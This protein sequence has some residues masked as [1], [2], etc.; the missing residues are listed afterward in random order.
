M[1]Q[2][3]VTLRCLP[4]SI[5]DRQLTYVGYGY[6]IQN[7]ELA[8]N[9]DKCAVCRYGRNI[10]V[11]SDY[12]SSDIKLQEVHTVKDLGVT[13]D[14]QLKFSDH[15]YD[16]IKKAYSVLGLIK[17]NSNFLCRDSFVMLYKSMVRSH[18]EYANAVWNPHKEGLIKDL[19]WIQMR[20]TKLVSGL[21]KN[22]TGKDSWS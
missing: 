7:W 22:V 2:H 8:L 21:K 12:Y 20:A 17:R 6:W 10:A 18:L 19:E 4:S 16:K 11:K 1:I 5:T 13:F 9:T 3:C 15:Y 14:E